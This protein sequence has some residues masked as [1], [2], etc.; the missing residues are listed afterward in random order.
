MLAELALVPDIFDASNYEGPEACDSSIRA[1]R[2]P[3]FE[4]A[5]V[6]DLRD[7]G[8]SQFVRDSYGRLH[9]R[10]KEILKKLVKSRRLLLGQGALPDTPTDGLGWCREAL[11]SHEQTSLTAVVATKPICDAVKQRELVIPIDS[12]SDEEWRARLAASRRLGR[13]TADYLAVLRLVLAHAN[14]LQFIDPYLDP[15]KFNYREFPELL[16]AARRD[17]PP[18]IEI[19]RACK[20]TLQGSQR[21]LQG[22]QWE[23]FFRTGLEP[24]LRSLGLQAE[25]FIWDEF[26]DRFLITDLIG[27]EVPNGFDVANLSDNLTTWS[28]VGPST[29]DSI[30]RE[31]EPGVSSH[32]CHHRFMIGARG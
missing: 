6:R 10:T 12:L 9:P 2:V 14:S 32:R 22:A 29:A 1:L 16:V 15:T 17:P 23:E 11:A 5:L 24:T 28:R 20:D 8:W 13:T 4:L 26:H 21:I 27:I 18:R 30:R 7:G 25:V 31:F 3:L 19:H